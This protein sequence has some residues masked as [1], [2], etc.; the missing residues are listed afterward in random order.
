[1]QHLGGIDTAVINPFTSDGL[2]SALVL[3]IFRDDINIVPSHLFTQSMIENKRILIVSS[4]FLHIFT[5][6]KSV[7]YILENRPWMKSVC[8]RMPSFRK[9]PL[10]PMA[11]YEERF[12]FE[13]VF[14]F[15]FAGKNAPLPKF[16]IDYKNNIS[17]LDEV[18]RSNFSLSKMNELGSYCVGNHSSV[19]PLI[20]SSMVI[21]SHESSMLVHRGSRFV[22]VKTPLVSLHK[23]VAATYEKSKECVVYTELSLDPKILCV[24]VFTNAVKIRNM[25]DYFNEEGPEEVYLY[26]LSMTNSMICCIMGRHTFK[27]SFGLVP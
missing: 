21:S 18:I 23:E 19:P 16:F 12:S 5:W 4:V 8:D 2:L 26:G 13:M 27:R 1:M 25:N 15:V 14:D 22:F 11:L 6:N 24:S 10:M 20:K 7:V 3:K 9:V 17:M